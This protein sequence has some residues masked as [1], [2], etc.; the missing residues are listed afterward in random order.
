LFFIEATAWGAGNPYRDVMPAGDSVARGG[1]APR[2]PVIAPVQG[3][4]A[5]LISEANQKAIA[6]YVRYLAASTGTGSTSNWTKLG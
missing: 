6:A 4:A 3:F 2:L 1:H 5:A